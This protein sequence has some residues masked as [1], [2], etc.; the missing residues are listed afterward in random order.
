M[1]NIVS[2]EYMQVLGNWLRDMAKK[3]VKIN[4]NFSSEVV[5]NKDQLCHLYFARTLS[6]FP[7]KTVNG[8]CK[9]SPCYL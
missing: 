2:D 5:Y 7:Q 4:V 8:I 3:K 6:S 9:L 1:S